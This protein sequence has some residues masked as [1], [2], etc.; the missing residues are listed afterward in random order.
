MELILKMGVPS[1]ILHKEDIQ[2]VFLII[3]ILTLSITFSYKL[4]HLFYPLK[5]P[6]NQKTD[7]ENKVLFTWL[8]NIKT[9]HRIQTFL[10]S[11]Y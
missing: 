1:S 5:D 4:Q 10:S 8:K 2:V 3:H 6:I 11:I 9:F 7:K